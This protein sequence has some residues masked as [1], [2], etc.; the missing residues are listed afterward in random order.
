M[1]IKEEAYIVIQ[2]LKDNGFEAYLV[3]GSVRD[4]LMN[5]TPKDF[6]IA[7][8][9]KPNEVEKIFEKTIDTGASFGTITVLINKVQIEVTTYRIDGDYKDNRHPEGVAFTTNLIEDLKRRDFTINAIAYDGMEEFI[10]PFGGSIDI[11]NKIIKGVGE[12]AKRFREDALRVLRAIRFSCQLGFEIEE[13]T[14]KALKKTAYLIKNISSERIREELKKIIL[15]DYIENMYLLQFLSID[16]D[17]KKIKNKPRELETRLYLLGI[18][19]EYMKALK[20][21]N[22]EIN[23][24]MN[25]HSSFVPVDRYEAKKLINKFGFENFYRIKELYSLDYKKFENIEEEP[26]FLKDLKI[27]GDDIIN[28]GIVGKEIGEYLYLCLD[29]VHKDKANNDKAKLLE[30]INCKRQSQIQK[31]II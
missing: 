1:K 24:V 23:D 20:F 19:D 9:A 30:V 31:K 17:Y 8:N 16:L 22:R 14:L 26:I 7:T 3:G 4:F 27:K 28:L 10:D 21:S 25:L 12:P 11:Q 5:I 2:T 15:S 18:K 6:D 29:A 13:N